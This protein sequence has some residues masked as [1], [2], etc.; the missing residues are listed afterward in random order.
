LFEALLADEAAWSIW[1][2]PDEKLQEQIGQKGWAADPLEA[3][4]EYC[5]TRE[6]FEEISSRPL[7][8]TPA[9]AR[10]SRRLFMFTDACSF[11][12]TGG[13]YRHDAKA[14]AVTVPVAMRDGSGRIAV[15]G[16]R[17]VYSAPRLLRDNIRAEDGSYAQD[18]TQPMMHTLFGDTAEKP[19]P[20]EL[21]AAAVQLM[22]DYDADGRR[23]IL[24]NFPLS[25]APK[26][27]WERVYA[28]RQ[29][30]AL[31][32]TRFGRKDKKLE[33]PLNGGIWESNVRTFW[34]GDAPKSRDFLY[35]P[36]DERKPQPWSMGDWW[37]KLSSFR[38]LAA[39]LGTR[40]AASVA[41]V[42][43]SHGGGGTARFIGKA[44]AHDWY[45]RYRAGTILRLP[46]ENAQV[47][48]PK[49]RLDKDDLGKAFREEL[50]GA[51]GR[52]ADEKECLESMQILAALGQ[53]ELLKDLSDATELRRRFSLPEQ[54][55]KL[56]VAMRR[57]Q[58]W[59]SL[60]V[61]WHWKLTQPDDE[62][63]RTAALT[64][65]GEHDHKPEWKP[66]ADGSPGNLKALR[67]TLRDHI[68]QQRRAVE[69]CLLKLTKRILPLRNRTW[70][71]VTHP[72]KS[73]CRLL[74]QTPKGS[75][76]DKAKL[77]GQRGLSIARIEQL[78]ELRRRWQSLNQSLRR[79]LGQRPLTASE[80]RNDPI[81]D[82]CPDLLRKL[83]NIRE[84]RVNQTAHLIVAQALGLKLKEP[85]I[86]PALRRAADLHG[87][88]AVA[89]PPVD[90]IVLEDL[91]RY[92]SDQGRAK[93]ENSRLMKWCH[94][95][96]TLKVKMLAEPFGLPVLETP[97]AYSSRF[98]SL[99]GTAGFRAAEV[100]WKDRLDFRWRVLLDEAAKARA[101]QTEPSA[102]AKSAEELFA[103]LKR[104]SESDRPHL[105]LL[106]PQP[107]GPMF[108][109][110]GAVAH[111][112]P[113]SPQD[114]QEGG[115]R[116]MQADLNAAAN[117]AF[118]AIAHPACAD[119]HHRVR[120]Q[121]KSSTQSKTQ[122]FQTRETRRFGKDGV[123]ILLKPGHDL[124][125]ERNSNLFFDPQGNAE[126]GRAKLETDKGDSYQYASGPGLWK[127]VNQRE[128][129]W[130]RCAALNRARLAKWKADAHVPGHP[131]I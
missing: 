58:N 126:F 66:L 110:A 116:P 30:Q 128:S 29:Q 20:Q 130:E 117:L 35:W 86:A 84:Q 25:L 100:G 62:A 119:I 56:L 61:S 33:K 8:F 78:S 60:C 83:E 53:P 51:R 38:V 6:S 9:D 36:T 3:F 14:L 122:T 81:P 114:P 120:T 118:R 69:E 127:K 99:T 34:E 12:K 11:G 43:A 85:E 131:E 125:K 91:S 95:A 46:G 90:L 2:E 96:I 82:P 124:P 73:D 76:Q 113:S 68:L 65:I 105:T 59:I 24:L 109:T 92:L 17:L 89:R 16:C 50:Y 75:N 1:R 13:D 67:N 121:R 104:I 106:A 112:L 41:L 23:R 63:Q 101:N 94:R 27:C 15:Q 108:V 74:R 72:D 28:L 5:E 31:F 37:E 115:V 19:N 107:G 47:L 71:W 80:M 26:P 7:N 45:A 42:E 57:A 102:N 44:G 98:C 10:Y 22:P 52:T 39:D 103:H 55:D 111:P 123:L 70:E 88:Y 93:S 18:W 40:H 48:R 87:E 54:N 32:A 79:E 64:Q 49:T 4:R 97:A 77:P 21:K 129:Q